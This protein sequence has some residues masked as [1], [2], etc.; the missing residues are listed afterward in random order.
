MKID[1]VIMSCNDNPYY[2]EFWPLVSKVW[3]ERIGIDPVLVYIGDASNISTEYGEVV[4]VEKLEDVPIHTQAQWARFWYTQFEPETMWLLS[5]IDMMP[6]SKQFFTDSVNDIPRE[7][8]PMV[9]FNTNL[10]YFD[11]SKVWDIDKELNVPESY[12]KCLPTCYSA[13][14]GKLRKEILNLVPSF[15]ESIENLKWKENDYD[16]EI[17]GD[18]VSHWYAEEAYQEKKLLEWI[19][20]NPDRFFAIS[21]PGGWC[22]NRLD[23]GHNHIPSLDHILA[24]INFNELVVEF[25]MPRPWEK[26][27]K[28]I[29]DIVHV[30]FQASPDIVVNNIQSD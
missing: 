7:I 19:D 29:E 26:Y 23:R 10:K 24:I 6:L 14:S 5:D 11:D 3:K 8:E 27:G 4:E 30:C 17:D 21:R 16:H 9:H 18:A 2:S 1:K 25:H 20:K 22:G 15:K 12:G 13:G 28:N